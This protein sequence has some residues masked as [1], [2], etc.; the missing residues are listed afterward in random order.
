MD[1]FCC[2]PIS[3]ECQV[4]GADLEINPTLESLCLS[5]TEHALGGECPHQIS[6]KWVTS[7]TCY[8]VTALLSCSHFFFFFLVH[9]WLSDCILSFSQMEQ[10]GH[11]QYEKYMENYTSVEACSVE[12]K[13]KHMLQKTRQSSHYKMTKNVYMFSNIFVLHY[14]QLSLLKMEYRWILYCWTEK[15]LTIST[16]PLSPAGLWHDVQRLSSP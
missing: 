9:K 12:H 15:R 1:W 13:D 8:P 6:R 11:Q 3:Q 7:C 5:M 10:T 14:I 16:A 2:F 4:P